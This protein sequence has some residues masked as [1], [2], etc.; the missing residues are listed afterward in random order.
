MSD[1]S[2]VVAVR[3]GLKETETRFSSDSPTRGDGM[4][5]QHPQEEKWDGT[6]TPSRG[7]MMLESAIVVGPVKT[8]LG[9]HPPLAYAHVMHHFS[10]T[11]KPPSAHGHH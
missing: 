5:R 10:T 8:G 7:E 2:T 1:E 11:I 6:T 9:F 3:R 4:V